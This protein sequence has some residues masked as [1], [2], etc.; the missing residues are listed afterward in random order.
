[1]SEFDAHTT[2]GANANRSR[3]AELA[4]S[5]DKESRA[6][7]SYPIESQSVGESTGHEHYASHH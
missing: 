2:Y 1:M 3:L 7:F 4:P 5:S 6:G